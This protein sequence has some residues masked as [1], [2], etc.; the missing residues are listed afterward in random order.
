[1]RNGLGRFSTPTFHTIS[2]IMRYYANNENDTIQSVGIPV[3]GEVI[4]IVE[5]SLNS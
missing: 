3:V 5:A 2:K 1:M 4:G